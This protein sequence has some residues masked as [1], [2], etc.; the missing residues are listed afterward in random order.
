MDISQIAIEKSLDLLHRSRA[1]EGFLASITQVDNYNRV[2]ARDGVICGLAALLSE[3]DKLS[4]GLK[5]T[6]LT[7]RNHQSDLG[8]IPS[9]V[10][11]DANQPQV[12][13]GGMCGRA[14]T[15]SWF[16][17]GVLNYVFLRDDPSFAQ[18]MRTSMQKG[19]RL[20]QA[21]EFNNR[22]LMYVPQSGDW[23]D[24][25]IL[26]GYVLYDQLLRLWALELYADYFQDQ[27][28]KQ[29]S[30]KIRALL[31][32]NY[33]AGLNP[34]EETMLYHANAHRILEQNEG[35]QDYWLGA[36]SPGGYQNKFDLFANALALLLGLGEKVQQQ[37]LLRFGENLREQNFLKLLPAFYPVIREGDEGW[38][39]LENNHKYAFRNLPHEFHNGG[40]W[41]MVN[42]FWGMALFAAGENEAGQTLLKAIHK[43]NQ[44]PGDA[45]E[46]YE[47]FHGENGTPLGTRYCTWS[48]AGALLLHYYYLGKRL[49]IP[50]N[51]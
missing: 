5:Q 26:R 13:F 8:H 45:W 2:W 27:D 21:W 19:M 40:L 39:E 1:A 47:N 38:K 25:Y 12:S 30:Q 10:Y 23:A 14:D 34:Q 28:V 41:P 37:T 17:I 46:F 44:L 43:V 49:Y 15:I 36:F 33:W 3:D 20:M 7:L 18:E 50:S 11:L 22:G 48:A 35:R 24:E 16:I 42:G 9:N 31:S 32:L 4:E 51:P 6:L 29:Q